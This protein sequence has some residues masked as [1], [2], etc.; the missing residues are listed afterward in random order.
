MQTVLML[1][2]KIKNFWEGAS[3]LPIKTPARPLTMSISLVPT[4][5]WLPN[6]SLP[7]C[8]GWQFW[9]SR[10]RC[11]A[12]WGDT[13]LHASV[14]VAGQLTFVHTRVKLQ[15]KLTVSYVKVFSFQRTSL[16]KP[17]PV[18]LPWNLPRPLSSPLIISGSTC[19]GEL[20]NICAYKFLMFMYL[21]ICGRK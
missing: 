5:I 4:V 15:A 7:F 21:F 10:G 19:V 2:K 14:N 16:L 3:G 9:G 1:K 20:Q 13:S 11:M 18:A 17:L 8:V 6:F 12:A